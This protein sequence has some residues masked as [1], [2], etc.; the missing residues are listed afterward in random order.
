MTI[1]E[2][3]K[4]TNHP[5]YKWTDQSLKSRATIDVDIYTPRSSAYNG[6]VIG[7]ENIHPFYRHKLRHIIR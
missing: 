2:Y 4:K 3:F 6:L 7:K 1:Q 5:L